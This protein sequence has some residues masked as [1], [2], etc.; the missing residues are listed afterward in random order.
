MDYKEKYSAFKV[1][2]H[3]YKKE[4]EEFERAKLDKNSDE[5][6]LNY[7]EEDIRF[8][9]KTF[10]DIAELYGTNARLILWLLLVE[11]K[12][13]EEVASMFGISRRQ[14]QYSADKWS[15]AIFGMERK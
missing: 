10:D 7:M 11:N 4:K 13:Q 8:V 9:E 2:C 1:S 12:T 3:M 6:M 14:V 15:R 5:R